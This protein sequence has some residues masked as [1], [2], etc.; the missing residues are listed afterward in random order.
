MVAEGRE[1]YLKVE[2]ESPLNVLG[3]ARVRVWHPETGEQWKGRLGEF[4]SFSPSPQ[5]TWLSPLSRKQT[6]FTLTNDIHRLPGSRW[7][8]PTPFLSTAR[9]EI[10]PEEIIGYSVV[11]FD[12]PDVSLIPRW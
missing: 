3:S 7:L 5:T 6:S 1:D 11:R 4:G 12:F 8:L 2:C 9:I 10:T